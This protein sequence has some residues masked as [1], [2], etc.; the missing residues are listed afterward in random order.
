MIR[1][2]WCQL[3]VQGA[4]MKNINLTACES[5]L[6]P[7]HMQFQL[8]CAATVQQLVWEEQIEMSEGAWEARLQQNSRSPTNTDVQSIKRPGRILRRVFGEHLPTAPRLLELMLYLAAFGL[9]YKV[10]LLPEKIQGVQRKI[11]MH[12]CFCASTQELMLRIKIR[13]LVWFV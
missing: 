7:S 8:L 9:I 3:Q 1:Q 5:Y 6:P 11:S 12:R 10:I 13:P 4:E 2:C